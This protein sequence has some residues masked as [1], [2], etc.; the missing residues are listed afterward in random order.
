M[1]ALVGRK[2]NYRNSLRLQGRFG[3]TRMLSAGREGLLR[4]PTPDNVYFATLRLDELYEL[5]ISA[6]ARVVSP[7]ENRSFYCPRP[8]WHELCFVDASTLLLGHGAAWA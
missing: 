7:V 8:R 4:A 1:S 3:E 5:A 2:P 6:G